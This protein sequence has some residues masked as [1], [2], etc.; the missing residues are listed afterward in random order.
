MRVAAAPS[1]FVLEEHQGLDTLVQTHTQMSAHTRRRQIKPL[2]QQMKEEREWLFT[3]C[4][5][6]L[7]P[8]SLYLYAWTSLFSLSCPL[9]FFPTH[10][11]PSS[12]SPSSLPL[13]HSDFFSFFP[14]SFHSS[15]I[16]L[17]FIFP[18]RS[19]K[20][21]SRQ[22]AFAWKGR[23]P[24]LPKPCNILCVLYHARVHSRQL[25]VIQTVSTFIFKEGWEIKKGEQYFFRHLTRKKHMSLFRGMH[26]PKALLLWV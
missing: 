18:P 17:I 25:Y 19:P 22:S 10:C 23:K 21:D 9:Y 11:W 13:S 8:P 16:S 15:S 24:V 14:P 12:F 4:A 2:S 5:I 26:I 7:P 20:L 6:S 1:W 3:F